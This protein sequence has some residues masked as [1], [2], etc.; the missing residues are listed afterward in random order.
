MKGLTCE[1]LLDTLR[2][3]QLLELKGEGY[4]PAY[5]D[6]DVTHAL[7]KKFGFSTNWE[8]ITYRRMRTIVAKSKDKKIT[9]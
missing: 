2:D 4:L 6:N 1:H 9:R 7:Y 8:I 5:E 3:M